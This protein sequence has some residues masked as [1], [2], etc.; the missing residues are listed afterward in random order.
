MRGKDKK[1]KK[2]RDIRRER[3]R[4]KSGSHKEIGYTI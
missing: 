4:Q 2:K 1:R 3:K